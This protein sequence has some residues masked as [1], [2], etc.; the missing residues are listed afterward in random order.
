MEGARFEAVLTNRPNLRTAFPPDFAERLEGRTVRSL[1][2]R[3][4]YLLAELSSNEILVMHLGMSG[5]FRLEPGARLIATIMSCFDV[6][7]RDD[8]VQRSPTVWIHDSRL[9]RRVE[10]TTAAS[11]R[12]GRAAV[13]GIRWHG[14]R[15]GVPRERRPHS[16]RRYPTSASSPAS[17]TFMCAKRCTARGC[18]RNDGRRRLRPGAERRAR[19][20]SGSRR[21]SRRCCR[22]PSS[23]GD[24]NRF[25][26]YDR[27]GKR[28]PTPRCGGVIR[29]I[30]QS[31]RSTFFCPVC[32]K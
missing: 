17:A 5:S 13:R 29:R 18:H 25:R 32:Q 2:R 12:S 31:G 30:T 6:V 10:P 20:P 21:R 19:A 16:K 7:G 14:A 1:E 3:G 22:T 11:V 26:V 28:C 15:D 8:R 4:K 27:E 23:R 24:D 9:T